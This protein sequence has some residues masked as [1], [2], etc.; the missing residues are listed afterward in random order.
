M[1]NLSIRP[2]AKEDL[3]ETLLYYK[4]INPELANI[5]LKET[6]ASIFIFRIT[7]KLF[8]GELRMLE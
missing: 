3:R 8:K 7:Q 5:F 2:L 1:N 4:E 6:E